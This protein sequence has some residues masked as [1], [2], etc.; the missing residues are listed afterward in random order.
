MVSNNKLLINKKPRTKKLEIQK[1][2][3]LKSTKFSVNNL[4]K[5]FYKKIIELT[6][7]VWKDHGEQL[8]RCEG[9]KKPYDKA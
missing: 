7:C 6:T 8:K 3:D 1:L 9:K 5:K 4:S 2:E